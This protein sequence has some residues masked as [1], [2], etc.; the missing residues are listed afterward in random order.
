[1]NEVVMEWRSIMCLQ[2]AKLFDGLSKPL[3]RLRL[4][5]GALLVHSMFQN[6]KRREKEREEEEEEEVSVL[7][8]LP[9]LSPVGW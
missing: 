5:F 6:L 3:Q 7:P 4:N 8:P 9:Q 2:E 1:M